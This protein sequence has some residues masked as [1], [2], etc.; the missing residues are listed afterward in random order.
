MAYELHNRAVE[1]QRC[2]PSGYCNQGEGDL[3]WT[4]CQIL[5]SAT[6]ARAFQKTKSCGCNGKRRDRWGQEESEADM[7]RL[8][9][10]GLPGWS[11]L[12]HFSWWI[13]LNLLYFL[14]GQLFSH[15]FSLLSF[16]ICLKSLHFLWINSCAPLSTFECFHFTLIKEPKE[17]GHPI[18]RDQV[19]FLGV[20]HPLLYCMEASRTLGALEKKKRRGEEG[21]GRDWG[22]TWAN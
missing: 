9:A 2:S 16:C 3:M 6:G 20:P 10:Q 17:R 5:E 18:C 11:L 14:A 15:W 13:I 8:L 4:W 1:V 19:G 12:T 22:K 21:R 7:G